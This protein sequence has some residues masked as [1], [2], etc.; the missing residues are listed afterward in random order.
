MANTVASTPTLQ[1]TLDEDHKHF[2]VGYKAAFAEIATLFENIRDDL[3]VIK[4][5]LD[6]PDQGIYTR[7]ADKVGCDPASIANRAALIDGL[8]QAGTYEAVVAEL[9]NPT[10][11]TNL[12]SGTMSVLESYSAGS[13]SIPSQFAPQSYAPPGIGENNGIVDRNGAIRGANDVNAVDLEPLTGNDNSNRKVFYNFGRGTTRNKPIQ[14]VLFSILEQ[15]ATATGVQVEIFSGGQDRAGTPGARRTG[16]VRHDNG[17]GAD[18]RIRVNGERQ[19][20]NNTEGLRLIRTFIEKC[21]QF[22]ATGIGFGNG[23]MGDAG[24]HVDIAW[25]N[26]RGTMPTRAWGGPRKN[27][28]Q[29]PNWLRDL[30][31]TRNNS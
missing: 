24:I 12:N 10:D 16:S 3:R 19:S 21:Y 28:D 26:N 14:R 20:G 9:R 31:G 15:A 29:A 22:G 1:S 13:S 11:F 8:K 23:Y 5:R 30:A 18:V 27:W 7:S 25:K 6:D 17:F 2:D 4:N